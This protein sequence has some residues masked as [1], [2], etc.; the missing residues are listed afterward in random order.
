[1]RKLKV[2]VK[3]IFKEDEGKG[4]VRLDPEVIESLNLKMGSGVVLMKL[5]NVQYLEKE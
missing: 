5:W 4:I 3:E 2:I 1:V